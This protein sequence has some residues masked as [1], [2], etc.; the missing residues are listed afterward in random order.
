M[1]PKVELVFDSKERNDFLTGF[2]KRKF[3]RR[4][5]AKTEAEKKYKEEILKIKK[6]KREELQK[7]IDEVT[8]I[9]AAEFGAMSSLGNNDFDKAQPKEIDMENHTVTVTSAEEIDLSKGDDT[10]FLGHN[11]NAVEVIDLNNED[12]NS[13]NDDENVENTDSK[14]ELKSQPISKREK[15]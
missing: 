14:N 11:D 15:S 2:Q 7:R 12:N 4:Q 5:K 9:R 1:K 13:N 10:Y 3:E 6:R 8:E